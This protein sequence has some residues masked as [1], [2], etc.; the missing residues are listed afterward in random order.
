MLVIDVLHIGG[1][2]I[3][4][5][6][7]ARSLDRDRFDVCVC[8]TKDLGDVGRQLVADGIDT[9]VLPGQKAGRV[10]YSSSIKLRQ[11]IVKRKVDVVHSHSTSALF[12]A[13]LCRMSLPALR[14]VHTFHF[15]NYPLA[16]RR[17]HVLE[18]ICTRAVDKLIAVGLA[19]R[20]RIL[21]TYRLSESRIRVVWNGVKSPSSFSSS[22]RAQVGTGDRLLV[23]TIATLIEQKGL[24]ELLET[25]R[26]CKD[27]GRHM[28]FVI[29]GDG[30]MRPMLEQRRRELGLDD[31]VVFTGWIDNAATAALPAFDV[32]FQTSRW[33]AMSIAI[34]E[35]MA[36]GK[37][38]VATRVGDNPHVI[39]DGVS[40]VL[41]ESGNAAV[42]ADAL[43][44]VGDRNLREKLGTAARS[45]FQQLFTLERMIKS[46]EGVYSELAQFS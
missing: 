4:V 8:C 36:S 32:F 5:R 13:S 24:F 16:S 45:R 42:M 37:P 38:I 27:A 46:Y 2:E 25:A 39:E 43:A 11:A 40:G 28:Q 34:L 21:A 23:G 33:E 30:P 15:G 9:F 10:D 1:A 26:R 41:V 12:D 31:T 6:D 19:Q 7:I 35:A 29:V 18:A 3:I 22:F 17:H 14:L 20:Q 44:R